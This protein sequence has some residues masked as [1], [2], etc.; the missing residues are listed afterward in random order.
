MD[1]VKIG[2]SDTSHCEWSEV[3]WNATWDEPT[4]PWHSLTDYILGSIRDNVI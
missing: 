4:R 1:H 2:N 3:T